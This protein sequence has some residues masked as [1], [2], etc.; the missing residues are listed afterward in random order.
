MTLDA[1]PRPGSPTVTEMRSATGPSN[2][3]SVRTAAVRTWI[4]AMT[5]T[6]QCAMIAWCVV[7]S[8]CSGRSR[9]AALE[10]VDARPAV[11]EDVAPLIARELARAQRDH[12]RFLVYLGASWC[13]PCVRFHDAA[14][15]GQLNATFG[16]V[17]MLVFDADRD[18]DALQRAGYRYRLIPLFAIPNAD[19][20]ASG[21][22]IE[23][24]IKGAA[25]ID[26][27]APRLRDLVNQAL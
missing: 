22:Q 24:S 26:N 7:A 21:R 16:D 13:E 5:Q 8:A 17:R 19:G 9:P 23:G 20:S 3:H 27:I 2:D 1:V 10:L 6:A 25:A 14:A 11:G 18:G 15:A 4:D 12:R